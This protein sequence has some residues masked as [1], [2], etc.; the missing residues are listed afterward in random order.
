MM[1]IL[2][3]GGARFIGLHVIKKLCVHNHSL[4]VYTTGNHPIPCK[5][6]VKYVRGDRNKDFGG[7]KDDFDVVIDMCAYTGNHV[8]KALEEISLKKY[9]LI[10]T[11]AAYAKSDDIPYEETFPLGPWPVWGD[12]NLGKVEAETALQKSG[13]RHA[14]LRPV[15]VLGEGN[16]MERESFIYSRIRNHMPLVLPEDGNAEV[17]FVFVQNVADAVVLLAETDAEGAYN[18]AG[19]ERISLRG[20]VEEMANIVGEDANITYNP[21]ADGAN[22]QEN[23]FPFANEYFVCTNNKLTS[24]GWKPTPLL[25]GL[26]RDYENY[27]K[28]HRR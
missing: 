24:L 20:L 5:D 14:T 11:V 23:A 1:Q 15:Y 18:C 2:V 6:R 27:Y 16:H 3:I 4:T 7:I 10:S 28:D 22:F 13:K 25:E 17:Q 9:I 19:N 12:Y 21:A 8:R 26:R